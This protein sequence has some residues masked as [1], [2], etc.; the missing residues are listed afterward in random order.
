[1][2]RSAIHSIL[3]LS[4]GLG[5]CGLYLWKRCQSPATCTRAMVVDDL[6]QS[7]L[8]ALTCCVDMQE[9]TQT[10]KSLNVVTPLQQHQESNYFHGVGLLVTH[11]LHHC[12]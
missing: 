9:V 1:M 7:E 4:L 8:T 3:L 5:I 11:S 2:T 12:N 10:T 6:I